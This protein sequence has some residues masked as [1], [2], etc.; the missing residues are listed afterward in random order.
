MGHARLRTEGWELTLTH[1][2]VGG[3]QRGAGE[4]PGEDHVYGHREAPANIPV[5]DLNVLNLCGVPGIA[6]CTPWGRGK[7]HVVRKQDRPTSLPQRSGRSVTMRTCV[8]ALPTPRAHQGSRES[9]PSQPVLSPSLGLRL[10]GRCDRGGRQHRVLTT[11]LHADQLQLDAPD[12]GLRALHHQ[13]ARERLRDDAI[14]R[15]QMSSDQELGEQGSL[16][17]D[18]DKGVRTGNDPTVI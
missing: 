12:G 10:P 15:V 6:F 1:F 7:H 3:L 4:Q 17:Q 9:P 16:S 2:E 18:Q 5:G 11:G 13:L 8:D 14:G